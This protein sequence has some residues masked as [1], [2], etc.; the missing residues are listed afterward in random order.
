[1]LVLPHNFKLLNNVKSFPVESNRYSVVSVDYS[2]DPNTEQHGSFGSFE[3]ALHY[4]KTLI[5]DRADKV[6]IYDNVREYAV[7]SGKVE[8]IINMGSIKDTLLTLA[9]SLD[10]SGHKTA[11]DRIDALIKTAA[12]G[13]DFGDLMRLF[14]HPVSS[15]DMGS[16]EESNIEH[17]L[18]TLPKEDESAEAVSPMYEE[19]GGSLSR[20]FNGDSPSVEE[21]LHPTERIDALKRRHELMKIKEM[22]DKEEIG[23]KDIEELEPTEIVIDEPKEDEA[24]EDEE[25]GDLDDDD[26]I[27]AADDGELLEKEIKDDPS[28]ISK[29]VSFMRDNPELLEKL[30][31][32]LV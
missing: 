18:E 25:L 27:A 4:A 29:V 19:T 9:D 15:R 14:D 1:M 23:D 31:L 20:D 30:L 8:G 22:L 32:M 17:G 13:E 28:T 12:T 26:D 6:V 7:C 5:P 16:E 2:Q 10:N 11:A 24:F 3:A 21:P